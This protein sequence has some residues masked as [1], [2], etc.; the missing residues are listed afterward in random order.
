[1]NILEGTLSQSLMPRSAALLQHDSAKILKSPHL[2]SSL[3][4][5]IH[6]HCVLT[7]FSH[8]HHTCRNLSKQSVQRSLKAP[9]CS[10]YRTSSC[11]LLQILAATH[12]RLNN[13]SITFDRTQYFSKLVS[14]TKYFSAWLLMYFTLDLLL[15][16]QPYWHLL[17]G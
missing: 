7:L 10:V 11:K 15:H 12:L 14:N 5:H 17:K 9:R 1:M 6:I 13:R 3:S 2:V 4:P 8:K 16:T